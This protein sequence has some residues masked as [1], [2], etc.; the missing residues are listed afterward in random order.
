MVSG[1]ARFLYPSKEPP[2]EQLHAQNFFYNL[3][4]PDILAQEI[5]ED[6][7]ATLEQFREIANELS[8]KQE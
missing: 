1:T 5:V 8:R 4:D 6:L 3:P 7:E 2:G